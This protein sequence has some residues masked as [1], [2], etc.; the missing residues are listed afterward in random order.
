MPHPIRAPGAGAVKGAALAARAVMGAVFAARFRRPVPVHAAADEVKADA[1]E[2]ADRAATAPADARAAVAVRIP[3]SRRRRN[4]R[5]VA[6]TRDS[7]T[8][9]TITR[10]DW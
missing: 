4:G 2:V 6:V 5:I 7:T 9:T 1:P 3:A 8:V 10:R